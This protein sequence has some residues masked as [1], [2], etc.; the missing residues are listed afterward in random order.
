MSSSSPSEIYV[1]RPQLPDHAALK[2]YISQIDANGIY[3]NIGPLVLKLEERLAQHVSVD[4]DRIVSMSNGTAALQ[5][6]MLSVKKTGRYCILP[7]WT[8]VATAHA[9][10][11]AGLEPYF[12]DVEFS[13]QQLSLQHV[14]EAIKTLGVDNVGAIC[15]VTPFGAPIDLKPWE[16]LQDR[17]SI[18]VVLDAAAAFATVKPSKITTCVSLHTT[19]ILP[20]GE[21]G[22]VIAP[23]ANIAKDI[24]ARTNFGFDGTREAKQIGGNAKMSEYHAAIGL[25]SL[26]AWPV[27]RRRFHE[28]CS[29]WKDAVSDLSGVEFEA[30]FGDKWFNSVAV[31]RMSLPLGAQCK[32]H[33]LAQGVYTR[34]WWSRGCL[35]MPAF[36]YC[37]H[38]DLA[39][40]DRL[41][42]STL[43]L[44]C[45]TDLTQS[46]FE[47][48]R[49]ALEAFL[50]VHKLPPLNLAA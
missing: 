7:S 15:L 30:G 28:L 6:S 44:P 29:Q 50:C 31:L 20:A 27:K 38:G 34:R 10:K 4:T 19:K 2:K 3:T 35:Q 17:T 45:H 42:A 43:G 16:D 26:D 14:E 39:N 9:A 24:R 13:N 37:E 11:S 8:F 22:F 36:S 21:G 5:I 32:E 49:N 48:M 33:L 1:M 41:A 23:D 40:T 25:A 46:D 18:P 47:Q 12:V